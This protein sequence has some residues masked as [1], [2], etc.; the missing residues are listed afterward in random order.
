MKRGTPGHP[1]MKALCKALDVPLYAGV[2]LLET[3]WHLTM[4]YAPAGNIGK[5]TNEAI[6][7]ELGWPGDP[8]MLV[9]SLISAGWLDECDTNRLIVHDWENHA[10]QTVKRYLTVH[11]ITWATQE[12]VHA[13]KN[14]S[15]NANEN[16][17]QDSLPVPVPVPV[18]VPEPHPVP[19]PPQADGG[20]GDSLPADPPDIAD[21]EPP[22]RSSSTPPA[23]KSLAFARNLAFQHVRHCFDEALKTMPGI[24]PLNLRQWVDGF[25]DTYTTAA[26]ASQ[27]VQGF[28]PEH[29]V[30]AW[31]ANLTGKSTATWSGNWV[32]N[33]RSTM[34]AREAKQQEIEAAKRRIEERA[35]LR[36][37]PPEVQGLLESAVQTPDEE[38]RDAAWKAMPLADRALLVKRACATRE[39][40]SK[41]SFVMPWRVGE[42]R[43]KDSWWAKEKERGAK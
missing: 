28:K 42:T 16:S 4:R 29:F 35:G 7:E 19:A 18:P 30:S 33:M 15:K 3:L 31:K 41:S 22:T 27:Y 39:D 20:C 6:A 5:F 25:F 8:D 24:D 37:A 2:G 14:A 21:I 34:H 17:N 1:K 26:Q 38:A 10:D 23:N 9:S 36:S 32:K 13:S 40:G 12:L 43:A 11:G